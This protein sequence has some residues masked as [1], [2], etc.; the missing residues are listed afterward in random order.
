MTRPVR[1]SRISKR[2][3]PSQAYFTSSG[4]V[5][6]VGI[7]IL[8]GFLGVTTYLSMNYTGNAGSYPLPSCVSQTDRAIQRV[9]QQSSASHSDGILKDSGARFGVPRISVWVQW[10]TLGRRLIVWSLA[11]LASGGPRHELTAQLTY[12]HI[13]SSALTA[14]N[15]TSVQV[16]T[17]SPD[18]SRAE[19]RGPPQQ[20][21]TS[22]YAIR[23]TAVVFKYFLV[24]GTSLCIPFLSHLP[25]SGRS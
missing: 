23:K 20:H 5:G 12:P 18:V 9:C 8:Q 11:S 2:S 22:A 3:V 17:S 10:L 7:E 21:R 25:H 1:V 19:T 13:I 6:N 16:G 14:T 24:I 15:F 4:L